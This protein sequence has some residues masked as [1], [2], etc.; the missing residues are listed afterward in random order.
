MRF[1]AAYVLATTRRV[2]PSGGRA[3]QGL[4]GVMSIAVER[5]GRWD[6]FESCLLVEQAQILVPLDLPHQRAGHSEFPTV[7]HSLG[8]SIL[9]WLKR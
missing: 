1:D 9:S 7:H 8:P 4:T 3:V 2:R 6:S 5:E